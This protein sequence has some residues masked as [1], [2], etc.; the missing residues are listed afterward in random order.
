VFFS[1]AVGTNATSIELIFRPTI[2]ANLSLK[3]AVAANFRR[4]PWA[5]EK[6][7]SRVDAA[8]RNARTLLLLE[9]PVNSLRNI[10]WGGAAAARRPDCIKLWIFL[11]STWKQESGIY[12]HAWILI[13]SAETEPSFWLII[14][15]RVMKQCDYWLLISWQH[16]IYNYKER[17]AEIIAVRS[18]HGFNKYGDQEWK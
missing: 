8:A 15:L 1:A 7:N 10:L 4:Q 16:A 9:Q 18:M 6:K 2:R 3:N 17:H 12:A 11:R 5:F 13:K 14:Q